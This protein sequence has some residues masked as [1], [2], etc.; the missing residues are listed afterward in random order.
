M[1][2]SKA[3]RFAFIKGRKVAGT[4]VEVGL[5]TLCTGND[6]L[7]PMTPIDELLRLKATGLMAQNYGADVKRLARYRT[8]L[9]ATEQQQHNVDWSSIRKPRG[10]YAGHMAFAAMEQAFGGFNKHW[11]I[12]AITRCPYEQALSR[13]KHAANK[14]AVQQ[15]NMGSLD[16][17]SPLFQQAKERFLEK[18]SQRSLR[19]NIDL[20]K[21][22][23]GHLRPTFYLRYERLNHD[24]EI[25]MHKLGQ[26][27]VDPLPHL[28]QTKTTAKTTPEQ[29]FKPD[30]IK[31]INACFAEEFEQFSYTQL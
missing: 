15:R 16:A 11:T 4:S 24:Y 1:I 19:T 21:D 13:I 28:K 8:T 3:N 2:I 9:L 20:Y 23:K 27:K 31:I 25:L 18:A 12:I 5:S 29:L 17:N 7:T 10:T 30:E 6:I 22:A 14:E 26:N